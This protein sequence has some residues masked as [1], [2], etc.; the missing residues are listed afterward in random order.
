MTG[1]RLQQFLAED[2]RVLEAADAFA[3]GD[4]AR[5]G[6]LAAASQRDADVLLG[7]QVRETR[8]LVA[9]ALGAGAAAAS[10]FGAGWGG[11]VWALVSSTSAAG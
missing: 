7:N 5:I 11:S 3:R 4:I 9:R 2:A 8:E 6:E 1:P 10:S